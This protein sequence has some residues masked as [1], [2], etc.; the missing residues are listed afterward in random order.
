MTTKF[1]RLPE[2]ID[3]TGLSRTHIYY[4]ISVGL[5]PRQINLCGGRAIAWVE[6]EVEEWLQF[7]I[8][9]TRGPVDEP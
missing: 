6:D 3:R 9:E 8:R 4:L 5:F 2:V 1:L 7:R